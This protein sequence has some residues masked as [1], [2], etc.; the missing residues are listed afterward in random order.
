VGAGPVSVVVGD[1]NLDGKLDLATANSD[2]NNVTI[3]LNTCSSPLPGATPVVVDIK[4]GKPRNRINL[5]TQR[6]VPVAILTSETFDATTVDPLSVRFGPQGARDTDGHGRLVDANGDGKLDLLLRFRTRQ[7]GIGCGQTSASL[8]GRTFSGQAIEGRDAIQ[9]VGCNDDEE[10]DEDNDDDDEGHGRRREYGPIRGLFS[11]ERYQPNRQRRNTMTG[12]EAIASLEPITEKTIK[13][14][15]GLYGPPRVAMVEKF[16]QEYGAKRPIPVEDILPVTLMNYGVVEFQKAQKWFEE[17]EEAP[18]RY[19]HPS[20]I[21]V[22][23]GFGPA[24]LVFGSRQYRVTAIELQADIAA[25]GQRVINAC[26]LADNVHYEVTDVMT[27][28]PEKPADTLISVLCLLHVPDKEG[29]MKKLASLVRAGGRAYIAD[30]YAKRELSEKEQDLLKNEVACPGLLTKDEY[31]GALR[32]AGFKI[33]RFKDVSA[34]YSTFVNNRFNNYLQ[35]D[36]LEQ[37]EELTEFFAAMDTLYS[38]S[39]EGSSRLGGCR[40]YLEK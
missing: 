26:G 17:G 38:S 18:G 16:L 20:L 12:V 24:G 37:F 32:G 4:P 30:F 15:M 35:K 40:V 27:F 13:Q 19:N 31:V 33:I 14:H 1:F 29:V 2:S 25:V 3:L 21:D 28:E 39:D 11:R 36:K 7:T 22:G 8:T 5:K 34:E 23:A 6:T 10:E 9:T